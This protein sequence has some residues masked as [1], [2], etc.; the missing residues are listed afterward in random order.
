[1]LISGKFTTLQEEKKLKFCIFGRLWIG[2]KNYEMS[3]IRISAVRY[4]NTYPLIYGLRESGIDKEAVIDIDHPADCAAKL[5][6]GKADI[7]LVP[8]AVLPTLESYNILSDYCIGTNG[9][10]RTV[11]LLSNSP[12][13]KINKIYLDYRSRTSVA[14][15]RVLAKNWW[16]RDFIWES[17]GPGFDFMGV[18]DNEGLV[19]IGDQCFA[20]EESYKQRIDLGAEWRKFTGLPFVFACWASVKTLDKGFT[21]RFNSA[22]DYGIN[23]TDEAAEKFGSMSSMPIETL[24]Q[25]LKVNIDFHFN[26]E[27]KIAMHTFF[28]YLKELNR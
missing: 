27:K 8:V 6:S 5:A 28:S 26:D 2:I 17:T 18:G 22:L 15:T 13:E 10:V 19:I 14:L 12:F 23:H 25:Y 20:M 24:R 11:M 3:K 4:A 1:M 7:G 16:K 9:E 21:E